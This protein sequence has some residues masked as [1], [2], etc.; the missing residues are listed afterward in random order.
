MAKRADVA[1]SVG[2]IP[3]YLRYPYAIVDVRGQ[4]THWWSTLRCEPMAY[5]LDQ[6]EW[7]KASRRV[8]FSQT[9]RCSVRL[10]KS[11]RIWVIN[12]QL[13][14]LLNKLSLSSN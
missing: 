9:K 11:F 1:C 14:D 6:C 7:L 8:S 5:I 3:V 12:N 10:I 13:V 2:E 4:R